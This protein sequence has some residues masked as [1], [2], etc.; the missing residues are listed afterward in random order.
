[1]DWSKAK[2]VLI[3]A[4]LAVCLLLSGILLEGKLAD[5]KKEKIAIEETKEYI[6][7]IGA[8]LSTE[9]PLDR[10]ALPVIFVEYDEKAEGLT[11]KDY[12][13][14]A[15]AKE[16]SGYSLSK[17]G[18]SSAKVIPAHIA[19]LQAVSNAENKTEITSIELV[20][21][22][23]TSVYSGSPNSDTAIPAW[24]VETS[25]GTYYVNAYAQ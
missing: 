16:A 24:R 10:P 17:E 19:L 6:K 7:S 23:D 8:E 21:Y 1:M 18:E 5:S 11:Y 12:K 9:I 15:G 13:V 3:I 22:I 4:L 20:Y 14:Y 25:N 2:S